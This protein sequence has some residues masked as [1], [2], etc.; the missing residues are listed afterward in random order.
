MSNEELARAIQEGH[1]ECYGELWEQCRGLIARAALRYFT[2][3]RTA[4][5]RA[6]VVV[7]DLIQCGFLALVDA[8]R[9]YNPETGYQFS[10]F[11]TLPLK[12]AFNSCTGI[13]TTHRDG[14]LFC[15]S[16]DEPLG[17]DADGETIGDL[18]PDPQDGMEAAEERLNREQQRA[19]LEKAL[20]LIPQ[21]FAAVIRARYF[22]G[23]SL[24]RIGEKLDMSRATVRQRETKGL[25][26]L[27]GPQ[28]RKLLEPFHEQVI[29]HHA[30]IGTG[31]CAFHERQASSVELAV[32]KAARAYKAKERR[33]LLG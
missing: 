29:E 1:G 13:K 3:Y 26:K 10:T 19:A 28:C 17:A 9:Y 6:G 16:L 33:P 4:C 11:L 32:E 2:A 25:C 22:D 24:E 12:N 20:D 14:M 27:R 7:D 15:S 30:W 31:L 21:E 8:V 5:D 23:D 18:V